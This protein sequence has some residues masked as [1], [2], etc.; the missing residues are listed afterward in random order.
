MTVDGERAE[1]RSR[2]DM[3][4]AGRGLLRDANIRIECDHGRLKARLKLMRGL[5][6]E[7]TASVIADHGSVDATCDPVNWASA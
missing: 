5:R 7:R 6:T 1:L 4:P 2:C 3:D